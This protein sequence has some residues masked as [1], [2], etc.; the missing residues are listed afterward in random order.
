MDKKKTE[1]QIIY[2]YGTIKTSKIDVFAQGL[3]EQNFEYTA[4]KTCR[5]LQDA[6]VELYKYDSIIEIKNNILSFKKYGIRQCI[7]ND[8]EKIY[9]DCVFTEYND[10]SKM[11]LQT[12][13]NSYL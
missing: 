12:L 1:F 13:K 9:E 10:I 6:I 11:I 3:H 8:N 2:Y 7:I 4:I 5:S